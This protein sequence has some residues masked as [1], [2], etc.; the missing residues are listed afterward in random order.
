MTASYRSFQWVFLLLLGGA[1]ARMVYGAPT[2][3]H[4]AS[5][6]AFA[7][8]LAEQEVS[9]QAL[10]KN[11][12]AGFLSRSLSQEQLRQLHQQTLAY[13]RYRK[14]RLSASERA[15]FLANCLS[16]PGENPFCRYLDEDWKVTLKKSLEKN[17]AVVATVAAGLDAPLIEGEEEPETQTGVVE[18]ASYRK[19]TKADV[20]RALLRGDYK[21]LRLVSQKSVYRAL[22]EIDDWKTLEPIAGKAAQS[23]GA[24]AP[25]H[26]LTALG[27]KAEEFFPERVYRDWA[28]RLYTRAHE[29][30]PASADVA[31]RVEPPAQLARFR[32]SLLHIWDSNCP[33]AEPTLERLENENNGLYVTRAIYWRARCV[34][35]SGNKLLFSVLRN[36]LLKTNPL[37][38][39]TLLLNRDHSRHLVQGISSNIPAVSFESKAQPEFNSM[40]LTVEL[41][42]RLGERQY[43]QEIIKVIESNM[44][45][46]EPEFRTYLAMLARETGDAILPFRILANVFSDQ[47]SQITPETLQVF[48]PLK[49]FEALERQSGM[50][51]PYFIAALI[52][53]ESGFNEYARSTAGAL[54]LMQLMPQTARRM[55]RV[56][57]RDLLNPSVNVRLGVRYLRSL[58]DR[59]NGDAELAL[60]SYNA[61]P[62]KVDNWLARYTVSD[63]ILFLDLIPFSETR[64]YVALIGRNY[65]WYLNLY[66]REQ[67]ASGK[68]PVRQIASATRGS[69]GGRV[70]FTAFENAPLHRATQGGAF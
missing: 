8:D 63:R 68:D 34:E 70:V 43:A 1:V 39:H 45:G 28:I 55:E 36:R 47:M 9:V 59:F 53:Q 42:L 40:V 51:D 13:V 54:G 37:G 24:C 2:G 26:V 49:R 52:R 3:A 48:Y 22:A 56:N 65:F 33:A 64:N 60:A 4:N 31:N 69:R 6:L 21:A 7:A 16:R 14:N 44:V 25:A 50:I 57:R 15:S 32:L 46:T 23:G 27:L 12:N 18:S 30:V 62:N 38:Y 61:G 20:R 17:T 58:L 35:K 29:C 19:I 10:L 11:S 5:Q 66:A 41:L 67:L